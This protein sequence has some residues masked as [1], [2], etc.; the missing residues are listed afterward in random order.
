MHTL[1]Q[2]DEISSLYSPEKVSIMTL[3]RGTN[4]GRR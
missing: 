1:G 4:N 2:L 3:D